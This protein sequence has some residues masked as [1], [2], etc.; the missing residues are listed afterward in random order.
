MTLLSPL[1]PGVPAPSVVIYVV[2]NASRPVSGEGSPEPDRKRFAFLCGL[3]C[4]SEEDVMQEIS[5]RHAAQRLS[6]NKQRIGVLQS[7]TGELSES[8]SIN[9]LIQA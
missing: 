5:E 4:N 7:E 1:F 3:Y 6:R 8:L 2:K 9:P